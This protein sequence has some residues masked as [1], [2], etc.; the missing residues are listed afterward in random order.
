MGWPD[1]LASGIPF[2]FVKG[3]RPSA[4]RNQLVAGLR[5]A[6]R[7]GIG[8]V[9]IPPGSASHSTGIRVTIWPVTLPGAL[10]FDGDEW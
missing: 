5:G 8:G 7:Y 4:S 10:G 9:G 2:A 6:M 3:A 1:H